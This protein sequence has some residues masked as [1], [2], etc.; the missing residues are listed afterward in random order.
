MLISSKVGACSQIYDTPISTLTAAG[1]HYKTIIGNQK[2]F[3]KEEKNRFSLHE[4]A[5]SSS[6]LN[7]PKNVFKDI[8]VK[9]F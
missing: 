9:M 2:H 4:S 6:F 5:S 7:K 3:L 8:G 1:N